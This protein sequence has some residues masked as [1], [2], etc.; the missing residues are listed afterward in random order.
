MSAEHGEFPLMVWYK[1]RYLK[2]KKM[3]YITIWTLID[4][5][6]A[7]LGY[8]N[9]ND[10]IS[11]DC[12]ASVISDSFVLTAAHCTA[13]N[14]RPV[15]VRMGKVRER[16]LNWIFPIWINQNVFLMQNIGKSIWRTR[17]PTWWSLYTSRFSVDLKYLTFI[18]IKYNKI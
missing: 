15:I 18:W 13:D 5:I 6:Q 7:A 16:S 3:C 10:R 17:N 12:G 1:K 11:Y 4:N 14:R 2:P 8:F 9:T